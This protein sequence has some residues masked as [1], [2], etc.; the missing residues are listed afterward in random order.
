MTGTN[1]IRWLFLLFGLPAALVIAVV[2]GGAN[3]SFGWSLGRSLLEQWLLGSASVAADILK[4]VLAVGFLVALRAKAK[5]LAGAIALLWAFC[6]C[7]SV[8]SAVG[9]AASTRTDVAAARET[10]RD[11]SSGNLV[12]LETKR[13]RFKQVTGQLASMEADDK[14]KVTRSCS[15]ATIATS[16]AFCAIYNS[17]AQEKSAL[18]TD[19]W[20]LQT[21]IR[22]APKAAHGDPQVWILDRLTSLGEDTIQLAIV[23]FV[24]FFF[25][26][27]SN[28]GPALLWRLSLLG[29]ES[30]TVPMRVEDSL[31]ESP[32][33]SQELSEHCANV[34]DWQKERVVLNA[35][36]ASQAADLYDDYLQFC[37]SRNESPMT[38]TQWGR[39]FTDL[40][41]PLDVTKARQNSR[42]HYFGIAL[43]GE[44]RPAQL[45]AA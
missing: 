10:A 37:E 41:T 8:L 18:D 34:E 21:Y 15:N 33:E 23:L 6:T 11:L 14:W 44:P 24:A 3:F 31:N 35:F 20:Q 32:N 19:L 43:K 12:L 16:I 28:I 13:A 9:F 25:E 29:R 40:V 26:L 1:K 4:I 7:Y 38:F 45:I 30:K 17:F 5:M 2:S 39:Q 22:E 42:V 27:A 36:A